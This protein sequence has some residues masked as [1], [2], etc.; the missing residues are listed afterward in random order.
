MSRICLGK[1][2]YGGALA[3]ELRS[4][5]M[6]SQLGLP[7]MGW[8]LPKGCGL[9]TGVCACVRF[10]FRVPILRTKSS[11]TMFG[12]DHFCIFEPSHPN[13]VCHLLSVPLGRRPATGHRS[14]DVSFGNIGMADAGKRKRSPLEQSREEGDWMP[15]GHLRIHAKFGG[16][17]SFWEHHEYILYI[18]I[19]IYYNIYIY[20]YCHPP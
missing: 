20:I 14:P 3:F 17:G 12:F 9:K 18:Y 10:C 16:Y 19:Y 6:L 15:G 7:D 5:G 4:G 13:T 1:W 11:P 2:S 8:K